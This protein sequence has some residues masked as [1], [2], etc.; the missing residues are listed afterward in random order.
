MQP[1]SFYNPQRQSQIGVGLIFFL[2]LYKLLRGLWAVGVYLIV[3]SPSKETW[4]Y[5]GLGLVILG[6]LVLAYSFLY[7]RKFLFHIDVENETFVLQKGVFYSEVIEISFDK[8]QQVNT[9]QSLLQRLVNVYKLVIDTAGGKEKEVVIH[10]ISKSKANQLSAILMEAKRASIATNSMEEDSSLLAEKEKELWHYK[11]NVLTLL[12]IGISSNYLRGLVLIAA[13]FSSIFQELDRWSKDSLDSYLNEIPDPSN[14]I[15]NMVLVGIVLLLGSILITIIEIFVRY[16]NL[17][18]RRTNNSMQ[19]QMGLETNKKILLQPRRVQLLRIKTNLVQKW[20]NLYEIQI[21]LAGI[22]NPL[23]KNKIKI[24]GLSKEMLARVTSFL[25]TQDSQGFQE[26]FKPHWALFF[27]KTVISI[28]SISIIILALYFVIEVRFLWL[29]LLLI[30]F[31][32]SVSFYQYIQFKSMKLKISKKF[33][34]KKSGFWN[35]VETSIEIY[36]VQAITIKE[37][38]FY[39]KRNLVNVVFHTAGGSLSFLAVDKSILQYLNYS[40]YVIESSKKNWM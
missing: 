7:Y 11:M 28:F 5:I 6:F 31:C 17:E 27:K 36:K 34:T 21:S 10:A 22:E 2:T 1:E 16:F 9:E 15:S 40:L 13:F 4:L 39:Q 20:L 24:P 3:G 30:I 12:K 37:P 32:F 19:L 29:F 8:I 26:T 38:Y 25:F 35:R 14:S 23:G 33:I 18:L